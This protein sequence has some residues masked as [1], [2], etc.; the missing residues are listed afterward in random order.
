MARPGR[1]YRTGDLARYWPDG[2]LRIR[3]PRRSPDQGQRVSRRARRSRG[4]AATGAAGARGGGRLGSCARWLRR[5]SRGGLPGGHR[6]CRADRGAYSRGARRC[7][8]RAHDSAPCV[9][10]RAHPV[11]RRWRQDRPAC[12]R[13]PARRGG[14]R[15][16]ATP[17][18]AAP[19]RR[20]NPLL[21]HRR[22]LLGL[23]RRRLGVDD[24]FFSLGG[25][26]VLATQAVAR[27]RP[28][29]D[30]PDVDGRRRLRHP[31]R[32][33]HLPNCSSAGSRTTPDSIRWPS[34]TWNHPD[35][36]RLDRVGRIDP[37][38]RAAQ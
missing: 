7:C 16:R 31:D 24:D 27:I 22:E 17:L 10:T 19:R 20:W 11:H 33:R 1:W 9:A 3:R 21:P 36:R 13:R 29:L 30:A 5:A 37:A 35:G 23:G 26:S 38:N 32:C 6:R 12:R 8:S 2:T 4:R 14:G 25:D 18:T 28:W 15:R 34:C